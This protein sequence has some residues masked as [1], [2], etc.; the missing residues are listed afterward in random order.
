MAQ[1][2]SKASVFFVENEYRAAELNDVERPAD[3][4]RVVLIVTSVIQSKMLLV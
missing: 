2:S 3:D 4:E 1:Y